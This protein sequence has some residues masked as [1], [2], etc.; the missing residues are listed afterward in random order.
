MHHEK[1]CPPKGNDPEAIMRI[2][3][4]AKDQHIALHLRFKTRGKVET[5]NCH[6]FQVLSKGSHGIDMMLMHNGTINGFGNSDVS[7]TSDF[8]YSVLSPLM[9]MYRIKHEN[10]NHDW[11]N[12]KFLQRT[13]TILSDSSILFLMDENGKVLITNP[14]S[15]GATQHD[16][17]WSSNT[18]SFN[19]GYRGGAS[20]TQ[21]PT[22]GTYS[23]VPALVGPKATSGTNTTVHGTVQA[24]P[25]NNTTTSTGGN[26]VIDMFPKQTE[27][28]QKE[29]QKCKAFL[30]VL[31]KKTVSDKDYGSADFWD[32]V[33]SDRPLFV[34]M[35]D[36]PDTM[37]I[38]ALDQSEIHELVTEY[39]RMTVFL[40]QE[41]LYQLWEAKNPVADK[42]VA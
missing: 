5:S 20:S 9:D 38:C 35:V 13:L 25:V 7:D 22:K 17:W 11:Q 40:I 32:Y 34:D 19:R 10:L 33:A 31:G 42:G 28:F 12:D 39:P 30:E 6:P 37:D 14:K 8:N 21:S 36:L 23:G 27:G 3:E 26:K 4:D 16:G 15:N 24:T 41:L 1:H 18:Y 29:V 2:L